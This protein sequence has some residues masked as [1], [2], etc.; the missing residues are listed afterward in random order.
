MTTTPA[1]S[2]K[3]QCVLRPDSWLSGAFGEESPDV[4]Q[5]VLW[6]AGRRR[7]SFRRSLDYV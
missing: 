6:I 5:L 3:G 2:Y 4:V 1:A 7:T